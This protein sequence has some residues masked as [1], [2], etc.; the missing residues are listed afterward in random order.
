ML[1]YAAWLKKKEP[2]PGYRP[3]NAEAL[4]EKGGIPY[5]ILILSHKIIFEKRA[6]IG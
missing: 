4:R 3:G 1:P 5:P 2:P 6:E